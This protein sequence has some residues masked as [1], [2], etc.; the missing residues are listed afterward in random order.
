MD[1][2]AVRLAGPDMRHV[3]M[4]DLIAPFLQLDPLGFDRVIL[5]VEQTELH[6]M[7]VLGE[8]SEVGSLSVPGGT[9]GSRQ[10]RPG[11]DQSCL[12]RAAL[13]GASRRPVEVRPLFP[14]P[15]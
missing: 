11:S 9:E 4:P 1:P 5:V 12:K 13:L 3:G 7:G 2:V 15:P 8:E 10:A 14:P 6:P